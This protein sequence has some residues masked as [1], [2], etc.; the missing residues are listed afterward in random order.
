MNE[1]IRV[2]TENV[3]KKLN[4]SRLISDVIDFVRGSGS[5]FAFVWAKAFSGIIFSALLFCPFENS[6]AGLS[7]LSGNQ[8]KEAKEPD[9][10]SFPKL[11]AP[12]GHE[13]E[14]AGWPPWII[15]V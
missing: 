9:S 14:H 6:I 2:A 8:L 5:S 1:E 7:F 12:V 10:E 3:D 4:K 11:K 15:C 13:D